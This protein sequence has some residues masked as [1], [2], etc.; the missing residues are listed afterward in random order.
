MSIPQTP[1]TTPNRTPVP[2]VAGSPTGSLARPLAARP[3][4]T[5]PAMPPL[6]SIAAPATPPGLVEREPEPGTFERLAAALSAPGTLAAARVCARGCA[7]L[8]G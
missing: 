2:S 7:G 8:R 6:R 1:H 3:G 5:P 4:G